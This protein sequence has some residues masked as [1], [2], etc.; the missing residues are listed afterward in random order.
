VRETQI[1]QRIVLEVPLH[2]EYLCHSVGERRA[3]QSDKAFVLLQEIADLDEHVEGA[4]RVCIG[5][6]RDARH[7]G[8]EIEVLI[9]I[10][11]QD[12]F[13]KEVMSFGYF[14]AVNSL[15]TLSTESRSESTL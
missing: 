14:E 12:P 6:S 10:G 3:S 11:N 5:K 15:I 2:G 4:L 1:D 9:T 8:V 13:R 7:L